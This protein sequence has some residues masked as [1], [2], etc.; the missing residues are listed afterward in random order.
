MTGGP[1]WA[2]YPRVIK[3][4]KQRCKTDS[5]IVNLNACENCV[6]FLETNPYAGW[7]SN[8]NESST[9]CMCTDGYTMTVGSQNEHEKNAERVHIKSEGFISSTNK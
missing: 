2:K 7:K 5:C 6:G 4:A 1:A 8:I 9:P 3:N